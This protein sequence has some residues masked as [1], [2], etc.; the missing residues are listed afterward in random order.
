VVGVGIDMLNVAMSNY[1]NLSS[2]P[3]PTVLCQGVPG[4]ADMIG[5]NTPTPRLV[6]T[7]PPYPGVYVNYHRWKMLGRR[8]IKA[9]YWITNNLDGRGLSHYTMASR[10]DRSLATYFDRLT[11]SFRDI[12]RLL[13][14]ETIVVQMVGFNNRA[15]QLPRYL[16]AM[17]SAGLEEVNDRSLATEADGRLWRVVPGRRWWSAASTRKVVA[18]HTATEVV[19]LHRLKPSGSCFRCCRKCAHELDER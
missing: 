3:Q 19:L 7:S 6:L 15:Q 8:E 9:P 17:E 13:G 16:A 4:L 10:A 18:S 5:E 11:A 14:P 2:M 1:Q 12:A